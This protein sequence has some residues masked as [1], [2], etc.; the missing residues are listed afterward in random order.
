MTHCH[1]PEG[2]TH[3]DCLFLLRNSEGMVP[4]PNTIEEATETL[5]SYFE[6]GILNGHSLLMLEQIITQVLTILEIWQW[7]RVDRLYKI[8]QQLI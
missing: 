3:R 2:H 7:I 6:T 5:P 8:P 1:L 4:L